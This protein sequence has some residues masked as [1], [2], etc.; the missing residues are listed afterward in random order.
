MSGPTKRKDPDA[1]LRSRVAFL[2]NVNATLRSENAQFRTGNNDPFIASLT[3]RLAHAE[4]EREEAV[5][6]V[7]ESTA[8]L[9][10]A[11]VQIL[12]LKQ[13]LADTQ[14][15]RP[16]RRSTISKTI[17]RRLIQLCHPDKHSNSTAAN[18]ATIWLMENRP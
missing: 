10:Q 11:R 3:A 2:E 8:E 6:Q 14:H 15:K 7:L 17:W 4:K 5:K 13:E 1:E 16:P 18:E 12:L 9:S